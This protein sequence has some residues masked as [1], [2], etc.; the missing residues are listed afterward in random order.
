M[1]P[2]SPLYPYGLKHGDEALPAEEGRWFLCVMHR[3]AKVSVLT[4]DH[5]SLGPALAS[6]VYICSFPP[7]TPV[8]CPSGPWALALSALTR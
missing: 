6:P 8:L 4:P 1:S 3:S 5:R 7:L 2:A